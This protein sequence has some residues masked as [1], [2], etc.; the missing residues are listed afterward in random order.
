MAYT[1]EQVMELLG[2]EAQAVPGAIV[3]FRDKHI[4]VARVS[5][6][7]GFLVTPEGIEI[8]DALSADAKPKGRSPKQKAAVVE[9]AN[10][11]A[12]EDLDLSE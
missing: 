2:D 10:T 11:L 6:K 12:S 4:D 5:L 1:Y 7:N 8:L 9:S 3:V